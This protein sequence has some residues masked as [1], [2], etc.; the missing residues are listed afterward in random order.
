M[1]LLVVLAVASAHAAGPLNRMFPSID[2]N[3]Y[4]ACALFDCGKPVTSAE[5]L[6]RM[7][8]DPR[9]DFEVTGLGMEESYAGYLTVNES[10]DSNMFF[11]FFP[12]QE[13]AS[14]PQVFPRCAAA[15]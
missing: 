3:A 14:I 9:K 8:G 13:R 10:A 6:R 12:A 15:L 5:V 4:R 7:G 1:L 11:W 2:E